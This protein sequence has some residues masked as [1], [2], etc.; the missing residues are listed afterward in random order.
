MTKVNLQVKGT[1]K[2]FKQLEKLGDKALKLADA[3]TSATANDIATAAKRYAPVDLGKLRQSI[4]V[5]QPIDSKDKIVYSIV[6]SARYAPYMEFGTG[7]LVSVPPELQDLAI[8]FKGKGIREVNLLP[9][10][11]M[12]PAFVE[13]KAKYVKRLKNVIKQLS[14]E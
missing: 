7:K 12:Y 14:N 13:N 5:A 10:P 4:G 3:E 9:Q 1:K 2:L 11:Y 6:A 8:L